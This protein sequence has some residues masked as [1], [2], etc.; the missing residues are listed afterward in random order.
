M[1]PIRILLVDDHA[2][3]RNG[4][5]FVLEK[6]QGWEICGEAA[7]GREG[8]AVAKELNPDVVIQDVTLP[9]LS[10]IEAL[11]QIK[12]NSPGTEVII[13]TAHEMEDLVHQVF[14]AGG[15][16]YLLKTDESN[17]LIEAVRAAAEHKPYFTPR[18]SEIIFS[19]LQQS[20]IGGERPAP[21]Q[22]LTTRERE[23]VQFIAEGKSNKD[24]AQL[25]GVSL[26]TA[27]SHRAAIM[28]KLGLNTIGELIRYALRN[29]I[30]E[31]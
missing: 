25:M 13:F 22:T 19:R 29:G 16:S 4:V 7:T 14:D 2:V 23:A 9:E 26:R 24:L 12:R 27:E 30:I 28:Q 8:V 1:K 15:R 5:R 31:L 3:V 21:G 11:K 6:Q 10:G 18:V 17:H 20:A